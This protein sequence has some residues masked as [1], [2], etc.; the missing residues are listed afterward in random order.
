MKRIKA[1][2][3]QPQ[4]DSAGG[5]GVEG[6]RGEGRGRGPCGFSQGEGGGRGAT[7]VGSRGEG[8]IA[9]RVALYPSSLECPALMRN[10]ISSLSFSPNRDGRSSPLPRKELFSS[11]LGARRVGFLACR[12][13]SWKKV[14]F[15][16][17]ACFSECLF[18]GWR[19]QSMRAF[20]NHLHSRISSIVKVIKN[21][22]A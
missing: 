7:T 2:R 12:H 4:A 13:A 8:L 11:R 9:S 21:R 20:R 22:W 16:A 17:N 19:D 6:G 3:D 1:L 10:G 14:T 5:Q 18:Q 15:S